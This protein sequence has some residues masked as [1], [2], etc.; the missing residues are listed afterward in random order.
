M[1]E[2]KTLYDGVSNAAWGYFFLY[3]NI[4]LGAVNI[5]PRFVGWLLFLA[6]I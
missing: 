2:R 4:N 3:F 6:A 1:T 5:L